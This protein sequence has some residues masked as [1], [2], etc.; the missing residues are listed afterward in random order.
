MGGKF[1]GQNIKDAH[2]TKRFTSGETNAETA[3]RKNQVDNGS[4]TVN[5]LPTATKQPEGNKMSDMN[6]NAAK[7][8]ESAYLS[9]SLDYKDAVSQ[10]MAI[11]EIA[12]IANEVK[13]DYL[14]GR[15]KWDAAREKMVERSGLNDKLGRKLI[16]PAHGDIQKTDADNWQAVLPMMRAFSI[17]DKHGDKIVAPRGVEENFPDLYFVNSVGASSAELSNEEIKRKIAELQK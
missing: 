1:N 6:K 2:G 17:Y 7:E 4:K 11:P 13:R 3:A 12:T 5:N 16:S 15:V 10:L 8:I 9:K 14:S